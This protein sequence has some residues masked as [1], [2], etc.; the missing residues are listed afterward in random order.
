MSEI[1][2][3]EAFERLVRL[4]DAE[5]TL[6]DYWELTGGVSAEVTALEITRADGSEETWVVRRHGAANLASNPQIAADE[7]R[8]LELLK[9]KGLAVPTPIFVDAAGAV[10]GTPCLVVEYI[11]GE[12]EFSR[13]KFTKVIDQFCDTLARIHQ[14]PAEAVTFLPQQRD[15]LNDKIS[16]YA[17]R[18][19]AAPNANRIRAALTTLL[20]L[21]SRNAPVLL[22]GDYWMG[23]V[24]WRET[25]LSSVIDW[26]DAS[27]GDP[28]A[29]LANTR[30]EVLWAFGED[31]MRTFTQHYQ[32]LMPDVDTTDLPYWDLAAALRPADEIAGW[33][34]AESAQVLI[35]WQAWFVTQALEKI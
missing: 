21:P 31:V 13:A 35:A 22:H 30:L 3:K 14:I 7:F 2:Q 32:M 15:R 10:F 33:M 9:G 8:L 1:D 4:V 28:L 27:V 26:E 25:Q 20:E 34:D 24:L 19:D 16:A 18:E 17:A 5:A 23:N 6:L 29:D 11:E 12:S